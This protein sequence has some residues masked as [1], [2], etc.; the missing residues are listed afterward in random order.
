MNRYFSVWMMTL[1]IASN[2]KA[3]E[4]K[5]FI[6][7]VEAEGEGELALKA[8]ELDKM[9]C[10]AGAEVAKKKKENVLCAHEVKAMMQHF[11]MT[12]NLGIDTARTVQGPEYYFQNAKVIFRSFVDN[13]TTKNGTLVPTLRIQYLTGGNPPVLIKETRIAISKLP[14]DHEL[15]FIEDI[16][17]SLLQ[18]KLKSPKR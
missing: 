5:Y 10:L 8:A 18:A 17:L 14:K 13:V 11:A 16:M 4:T 7:A 6:A 15:V 3:N 9:V 1:L 12:Q 2:V